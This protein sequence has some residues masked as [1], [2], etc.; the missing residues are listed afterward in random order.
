[1]DHPNPSPPATPLDC[2]C[3]GGR[4]AECCGRFIDGGQVPASAE[5]LMRS[6]YTAY[7]LA[8]GDY[9]RAT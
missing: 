2:P 5:Q 4:Y 6:R 8:R 1:M 3:G 9:L 7:V